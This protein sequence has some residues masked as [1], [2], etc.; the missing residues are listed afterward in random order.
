M[1]YSQARKEAERRRREAKQHAVDM[2]LAAIKLQRIYRGR[3]SRLNYLAHIAHI[4]KQHKA[5][6]WWKYDDPSF[7]SVSTTNQKHRHFFPPKAGLPS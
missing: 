3:L 5:A 2:E 6:A 7:P 4:A 1:L